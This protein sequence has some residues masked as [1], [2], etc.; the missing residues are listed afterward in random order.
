MN[1]K[2]HIAII[3]V[4]VLTLFIVWQVFILKPVKT[5][6]IVVSGYSIKVSRAS[7]GLACNTVFKAKQ[8]NQGFSQNPYQDDPAN[9]L[10]EENNVY[11]IVS[12]LCDGKPSCEFKVNDESMQQDPR[13]GCGIQDLQLEFR[14]FKVDRLRRKVFKQ[15]ETASIDCDKLVDG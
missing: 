2:I 1:I 8:Q 11:D 5:E 14:C 12:R 10:V 15:Q 3:S 9:Q 6:S 7:Y 13:R 4:I